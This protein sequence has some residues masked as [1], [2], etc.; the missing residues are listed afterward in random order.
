MH[1]DEFIENKQTNESKMVDEQREMLVINVIL[2][3]NGAI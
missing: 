3:V 1:C 2:S